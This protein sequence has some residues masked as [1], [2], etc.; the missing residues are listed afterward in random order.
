LLGNL[1]QI[2]HTAEFVIMEFELEAVIND[3]KEFCLVTD[4][5]KIASWSPFTKPQC[6][7]MA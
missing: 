1:K 7:I 6:N 5:E 3:R 4:A 2:I